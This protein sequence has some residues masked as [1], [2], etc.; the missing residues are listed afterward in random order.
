MICS[1]FHEKDFC[2]FQVEQEQ[3]LLAQA[4]MAKA[5]NSTNSAPTSVL[6]SHATNSNQQKTSEG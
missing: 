6:M 1:S 3:F 2:S 5:S 4:Q